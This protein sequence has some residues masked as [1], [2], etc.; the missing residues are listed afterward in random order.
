M[1]SCTCANALPPTHTYT[2]ILKMLNTMGLSQY[3]E[4]FSS[5]HINGDLLLECD[6]KMLQY[7]TPCMY[8]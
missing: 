4:V 1:Q 3:G 7:V 6:D 8:M 2:Q 5:Q